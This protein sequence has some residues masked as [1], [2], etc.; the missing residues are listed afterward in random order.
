MSKHKPA[1]ADN[2]IDALRARNK[3]LQTT[4]ARVLYAVE[5]VA[6][7]GDDKHPNDVKCLVDAIADAHILIVRT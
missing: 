4:L 7:Q 1:S 3:E 2:C 6:G 5:I